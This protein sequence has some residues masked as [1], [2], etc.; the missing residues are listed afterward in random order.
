[1]MGLQ[2][3][4]VMC[5]HWKFQYQGIGRRLLQGRKRNGIFHLMNLFIL[6]HHPDHR[7]GLPDPETVNQYFCLLVHVI[8]QK[9]LSNSTGCC[10]LELRRPQK[11]IF[12]LSLPL[13][14]L[15][16]STNLQT[17][18]PSLFTICAMKS[19]CRTGTWRC[20]T[21]YCII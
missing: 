12:Q 2:L 19:A 13:S 4:L 21:D 16:Q 8:H 18:N 7:D 15:V 11:H 10:L 17:L 1:M 3:C 6:H 9:F 5:R 20:V 14:L